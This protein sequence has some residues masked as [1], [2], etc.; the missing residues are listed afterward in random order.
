MVKYIAIV[1]KLDW[2]GGYVHRTLVNG[3]RNE[4]RE[5]NESAK[6]TH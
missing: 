3:G 6:P 5:K 1:I 2:E 4:K